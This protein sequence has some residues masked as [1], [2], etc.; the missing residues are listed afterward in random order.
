MF[1]LILRWEKLPEIVFPCREFFFFFFHV[2]LKI[3][4]LRQP[5]SWNMK[6]FLTFFLFVIFTLDIVPG[7]CIK[8]SEIFFVKKFFEFYIFTFEIRPGRCISPYWEHYCSSSSCH[9]ISVQNLCTIHYVHYEN[10]WN[11][12]KLCLR[13]RVF[14]AF[15]WFHRTQLELF[16]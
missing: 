15:V 7:Y 1:A 12:N 2:F 4:K 11:K 9:P 10:W 3:K 13:L 8:C 5:L 6:N 14:H 16:R